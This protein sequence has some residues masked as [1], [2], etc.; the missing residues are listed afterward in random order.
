MIS[1]PAVTSSPIRRARSGAGPSKLARSLTKSFCVVKTRLAPSRAPS[2]PASR[3]RPPSRGDDRERRGS[4][5]ARGTRAA[6]CAEILPGCRSRRTPRPTCPRAASSGEDVALAV[7]QVERRVPGFD[8]A[9]RPGLALGLGPDRRSVGRADQ[10]GPRQD[11]HAGAAERADR[12]AEQS[13]REQSARART[14]RGHRAGP[15]RGRAPAA[16]AGTRRRARSARFP[17]RGRR[18]AARATR[19]GS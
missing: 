14:A 17:A 16:D 3:H 10:V 12:L 4:R 13:A 19:S 1:P 18:P 5:A 7:D 6:G 9:Q 11:D 15:R 2:A 8:P